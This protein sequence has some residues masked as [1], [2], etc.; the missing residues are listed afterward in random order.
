[1]INL[2]YL[3]VA[4]AL[5]ITALLGTSL[6]RT[7]G[8]MPAAI[9]AGSMFMGCIGWSLTSLHR[10]TT[11]KKI[12]PVYTMTAV[13]LYFHIAEEYLFEFGPRIGA[14]TGTGWTEAEFVEL[15]V[16][17]LP[18]LWIVGAVLLYYKNPLGGFVSWFVFLGMFLGEPTHL[19]VFPI[20]EGGRYHYFP[21]MWTALLPLVFGIWGLKIILSDNRQQRELEKGSAVS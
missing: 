3:Y 2:K 4:L 7:A 9:V 6:G 10:P 5:I 20:I 18:A 11:V 19:L 8:I 16:F 12:L 13:L 14:L 21:G 1:M 15:I 17:Y